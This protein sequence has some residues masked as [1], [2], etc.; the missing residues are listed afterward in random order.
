MSGRREL[1]ILK[2]FSSFC[3]RSIQRNESAFCGADPLV[4]GPTPSSAFP[5][6]DAN[7]RPPRTSDL[8]EI[9][10][11]LCSIHPKERKRVLWGGP[12]GPR[13]DALVGLS[14]CGR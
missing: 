10:L 12:P 11:I 5:L 1:Q 13:P 8:K 2:R 9:L 7:E 14:T 4:R 3:V 6:A